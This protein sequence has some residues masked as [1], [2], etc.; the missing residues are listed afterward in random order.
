MTL[1]SINFL[2]FTLSEIYPGQDFQ[3][4]GQCHKVKG[5]TMTLHTYNQ[6]TNQSPYQG[7]TFYT[8]WFLR[9]S[10]AKIL[11]VNSLWL[12]VKLRS[13][14][15]IAHQHHQTNVPTNFANLK[16]KLNFYK[17]IPYPMDNCFTG[18]RDQS[19]QTSEKYVL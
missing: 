6:P 5:Y 8:L 18:Q 15:K 13:H 17:L 2:H 14:H 4:Q 19:R 10:P 12:R 16:S 11:K 1:Q 3:S 9:Y 7:S